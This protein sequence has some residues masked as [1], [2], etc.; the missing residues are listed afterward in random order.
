M[1][2]S[3]CIQTSQTEALSFQINPDHLKTLA[4]LSMKT[5]ACEGLSYNV[6][7][8]YLFSIVVKRE[9]FDKSKME[10]LLSLNRGNDNYG[11]DS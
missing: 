8:Y 3:K 5:Y 1:A 9:N 6:K 7:A 4:L 2:E 10:R 11:P